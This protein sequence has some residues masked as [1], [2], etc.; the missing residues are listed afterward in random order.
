VHLLTRAGAEREIEKE[1]EA[2]CAVIRLSIRTKSAIAHFPAKLPR[3]LALPIPGVTRQPRE[4]YEQLSREGKGRHF[5]DIVSSGE[6]R[7]QISYNRKFFRER[8]G[9]D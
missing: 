7:V 4:T 5:Q 9:S 1:R 2:R 6:L 8:G 3:N